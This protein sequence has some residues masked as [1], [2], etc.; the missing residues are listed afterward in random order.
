MKKIRDYVLRVLVCP[1]FW[2]GFAIGA[3]IYTLLGCTALTNTIKTAGMIQRGVCESAEG[4]LSTADIACV[5]APDKCAE[6]RGYC[7]LAGITK[8]LALVL[9]GLVNEAVVGV[10]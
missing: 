10:E 5:A 4:Q 9:D 7:S 8:D 6:I 3:V 2:I 1:W